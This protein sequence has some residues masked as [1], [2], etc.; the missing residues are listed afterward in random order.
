MVNNYN[1]NFKISKEVI[2]KAKKYIEQLKKDKAFDIKKEP[3]GALY[4]LTRKFLEFVF[5]DRD[6]ITLKD[7]H[8]LYYL[9]LWKGIISIDYKLEKIEKDLIL[10][11]K[12]KYEF[13]NLCKNSD[14][15]GWF[16]GTFIAFRALDKYINK[17][18]LYD[19]S[20]I[21][22]KLLF[23]ETK[24]DIKKQIDIFSSKNYMGLQSAYLTPVF[25][26]LRPNEFPPVNNAIE[27]NYKRWINDD[28]SNRISKYNE[29]S[30][31]M[32]VFRNELGL[33]ENFAYL[34]SI[35]AG[36]PGDIYNSIREVLNGKGPI[37][38]GPGKKMIKKIYEH[39]K[40]NPNIILYG[41]PGTGKTYWVRRYV[42][43]KESGSKKERPESFIDS[44]RPLY[45]E[46]RDKVDRTRFDKISDLAS[47]TRDMDDDK[48]EKF[49]GEVLYRG[50]IHLNRPWA[51]N[52]YKHPNET[53]EV[54]IK[55]LND[56][57][58]KKEP[59]DSLSDSLERLKND[60][61]VWAKS[62]VTTFL[63][64]CFPE[65][66]FP[67]V[68]KHEV[69]ISKYG[70]MIEEIRSDWDDGNF[71]KRYKVYN[72]SIIKL[73]NELNADLVSLQ[74][75]LNDI[76]DGRIE[77]PKYTEV[78]IT[79]PKFI[80]FHQ[81]FSY[82][83]FIEGL[84]AETKNGEVNYNIKDGI[85]KKLCMSAFNSLL[86]SIGSEKTWEAGVVP[87][88]DDDEKKKIEEI[89]EKDDC[90]RYYIVIDEINRG[91]ISKIFGELITLLE[92]DK[93]IGAVNELIVELPYSRER[94]GVPPNLYVIGTMNST[95]RSIAL[96]DT[97]LRRRFSFMELEPEDKW[98]LDDVDG[99]QL[100]NI[101]NH[102]NNKIEILKDRDHRIGHSY[103]MNVNNIDKLKKAWFSE[104]IPLL[105][106]HF[107]NEPE[108]LL[109]ILGSEFVDK[110]DGPE[111][112]NTELVSDNK[113]YKI[114]K[115]EDMND[116][117]FKKAMNN[118]LEGKEEKK[119][120]E[121]STG[122]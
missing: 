17:K 35:L 4:L 40:R 96:I 92:K 98:I 103:L 106:E 32:E 51:H 77:F 13:L 86:E 71:I 8:I 109:E 47:N 56:L 46:Y 19:L 24:E 76:Y 112:V 119:K 15:T 105:Q 16:G 44:V 45:D 93:R 89:L 29:I 55:L 9:W 52:I 31:N 95:D 83:E 121:G 90:P 18:V 108:K 100:K 88:L 91:N 66:F 41:P 99:I 50:P 114:K 107:Y 75:F 53:K 87:E 97:A 62:F 37:N 65:R 58:S 2:F 69:T 116:E 85:F 74:Y 7:F 30:Y 36:W 27:K 122:E 60:T 48:F 3:R 64:I 20:I 111:L 39:L 54:L 113:I 72:E 34:D 68:W 117:A 42:E 57:S 80:T 78:F 12:N 104:I 1:V 115:E 110:T 43:E 120:G 10:T 5:N 67:F 73:S 21:Y 22:K 11:K 61:G 14:L 84:T 25:H 59:Y 118:I 6:I 94:F 101:F 33:P 79:E 102:I 38:N 70:L 23:N 28:F 49:L 63:W 81:S 82:E 26:L